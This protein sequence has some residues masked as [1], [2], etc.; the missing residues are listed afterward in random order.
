[1]SSLVAGISSS[2]RWGSKGGADKAESCFHSPTREGGRPGASC[3]PLLRVG[4]LLLLLPAAFL[5][6]ITPTAWCMSCRS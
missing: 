6:W 5:S 3:Q 4:T 2:C 1:M